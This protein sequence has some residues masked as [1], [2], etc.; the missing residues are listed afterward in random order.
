MYYLACLCNKQQSSNLTLVVVQTGCKSHTC[1]DIRLQKALFLNE[2]F[3]WKILLCPK[4]NNIR[5]DYIKYME[6]FY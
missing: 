4:C 1:E 5:D 2:V 3:A 6:I